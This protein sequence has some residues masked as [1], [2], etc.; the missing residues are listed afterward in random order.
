MKLPGIGRYTAG[1]LRAFAFGVPAV[2]VDGNVSRV[3][4]RL[5]ACEDPID[6]AAGIKR[7][8]DWAG[9][10]ADP[11]R[12]AVYHAALMELGQ[13]VCRPGVPDCMNCPVA[14]FCAAS[15][16]ERLPVKRRKVA[17]TAV[18]E[19]AVWLR[20]AKGRLLLHHEG[21]NRRTGLWK[22]PVRQAAELQFLPV[23]A[24]QR[25]AITRYRVRLRVHDGAAWNDMC[26]PGVGESWVPPDNVAALAMAAP[27]RR[28]VE[29]LL[30]NF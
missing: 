1:A 20:D 30:E 4:A 14:G 2:L 27:F 15:E 3:L 19:H 28:V 8:W 13:I 12:P 21:G 22:L 5:L 11:G 23:I 9:D 10:L 16:P 26:L 7:T 24:E 18:D 25:Y 29:Q 17:V 6:D